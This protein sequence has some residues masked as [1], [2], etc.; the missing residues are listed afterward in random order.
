MS[1][2]ETVLPFEMVIER[3]WELVGDMFAP[4][5]VVDMDG[6]AMPLRVNV[7]DASMDEG[8]EARESGRLCRLSGAPGGTGPFAGGVGGACGDSGAGGCD[9]WSFEGATCVSGRM[10]SFKLT[11][12][13]S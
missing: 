10:S 11:G 8:R 4:R 7:E 6:E 9:G 1:T 13:S 5:E 3:I 12:S 2:V